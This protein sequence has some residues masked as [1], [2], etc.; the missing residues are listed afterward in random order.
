MVAGAKS[1]VEV[2]WIEKGPSRSLLQEERAVD[3]RSSSLGSLLTTM[4]PSVKW[5]VL[6]HEV[7]HS[8]SIL[9]LDLYWVL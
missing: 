1:V 6:F 7:I 4:Y 3:G 9:R 2:K 5:R 8:G